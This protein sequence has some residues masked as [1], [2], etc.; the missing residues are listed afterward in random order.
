MEYKIIRHHRRKRLTVS[1]APTGEVTVI[2]GRFTP[3]KRI[4]EFV[5]QY[6]S[7]IEKQQ[8]YFETVY[9][10]RITVTKEERDRIKKE[11]LP[12]M[13]TLTEKYAEIMNVSPK[14]IKITVAEK[15]WGSCGGD[16]SICYSY[17]CAFLSQRCK[18]YI[19]VHELSHIIEHNHSGNF[20]AV[21]EK[22]MPQYKE[23]EKELR[24][25]YIH[26]RE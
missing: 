9:H 2:A 18:E 1:V 3:E 14:S 24:G 16:K 4:E 23:A 20:Y 26:L 17:R 7:W 19:V 12:E 10:H 8:K 25:Y 11:F 13:K 21:M 6:S 22:Y 5:N 15:R